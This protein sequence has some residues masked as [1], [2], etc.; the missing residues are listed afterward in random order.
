MMRGK[1]L[2]VF[3]LALA[4]AT[5]VACGHEGSAP[6][7]G[8]GT[9][10]LST[11]GGLPFDREA[12]GGGISP[13]SA[14]IPSGDQVP[15]GTAVLVRLQ[16]PISSATARTDDQFDAV[17]ADPVV[18]D[19]QIL[20]ERGTAVKGRV[21][22]AASMSTRRAAGY[23]RLTLSQVSLHGK[24]VLLRTSSSFFKGSRTIRRTVPGASEST[25]TLV[26]AVAAGKEAW[27]DNA[28]TS[29][30]H[31]FVPAT[32]SPKDITLGPERSLTFHLLEPL[33]LQAFKDPQPR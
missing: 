15:A 24:T 23:L 10:P 28:M 18:I 5:M 25:A 12:Q 20:L 1:V 9:S 16:T 7:M 33:P 2:S 8:S 32:P 17:L 13:T 14:V 30:N 3:S 21:V 31:G 6:S 11:D 19:G 29:D 27:L 4:I 26:G 22:E